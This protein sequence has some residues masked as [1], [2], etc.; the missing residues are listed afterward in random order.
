[1]EL[2]QLLPCYLFAG[3]ILSSHYANDHYQISLSKRAQWQ[4]ATFY[5]CSLNSFQ[6]CR[7]NKINAYYNMSVEMALAGKK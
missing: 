3:E 2:W 6:M 4:L 7:N 1:V 5:S